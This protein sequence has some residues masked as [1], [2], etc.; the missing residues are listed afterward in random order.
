M[1][2]EEY[3]LLSIDATYDIPR[4]LILVIQNGKPSV[5]YQLDVY[6]YELPPF[7]KEVDEIKP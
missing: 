6:G 3:E 1:T 7:G 4:A 2:H 5:L